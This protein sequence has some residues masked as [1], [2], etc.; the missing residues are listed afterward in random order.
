MS[1]IWGLGPHPGYILY[2]STKKHI[3]INITNNGIVSCGIIA[4]IITTVVTNIS[5]IVVSITTVVDGIITFLFFT[6]IYVFV[7][8]SMASLPH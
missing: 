1:F 3:N 6:L 2:Q 8:S 7:K 4:A 5:V